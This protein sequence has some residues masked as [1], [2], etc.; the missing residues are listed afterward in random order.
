[1][2]TELI[3]ERE[4]WIRLGCVHYATYEWKALRNASAQHVKFKLAQLIHCFVRSL[5]MGNVA[6]VQNIRRTSCPQSKHAAGDSVARWRV[7]VRGTKKISWWRGKERQG[8]L[9]Y[10][11]DVLARGLY[12]VVLLSRISDRFQCAS[13]HYKSLTCLLIFLEFCMLLCY[14]VKREK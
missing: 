9:P 11:C 5:Q 10:V 6:W 2:R 1:M 7:H 12:W 4:K 14:I 8:R 3:V 13:L